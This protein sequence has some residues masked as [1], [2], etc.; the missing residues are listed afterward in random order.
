MS[1]PSAEQCFEIC[2][3]SLSGQ[4]KQVWLRKRHP[5]GGTTHYLSTGRHVIIVVRSDWW[6]GSHVI[7]Q[8]SAVGGTEK[9]CA[10]LP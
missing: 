3:A 5:I 4:E 1:F 9:A 2:Q 7:G 6:L 10:L 8:S